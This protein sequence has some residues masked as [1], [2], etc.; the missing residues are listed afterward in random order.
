MSILHYAGD[1]RFNYELDVL[2][3]GEVIEI[4]GNSGWKPPA[5]FNATEDP[6][7]QHDAPG[8]N[9]GGGRG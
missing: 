6:R 9:G 1:G 2:N 4:I 7:P 5:N 8:L 3:M